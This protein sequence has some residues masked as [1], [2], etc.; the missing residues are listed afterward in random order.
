MKTIGCNRKPD[1]SYPCR[2]HYRL[3]GENRDA[4]LLALSVWLSRPD[5]LVT[6]GNVSAT[7]RYLSLN[8][9]LTVES[10]EERLAVYQSLTGHAAIRMVL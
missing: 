4:M 8:L 5:A 10:E 1:I 2:W 9:E 6:D 7:G 3:I